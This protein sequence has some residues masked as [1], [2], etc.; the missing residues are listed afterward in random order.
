MKRD[1]NL[2]YDYCITNRV[3]MLFN[4]RADLLGICSLFGAS[5]IFD[6]IPF[7]NGI[8]TFVMMQNR[9]LINYDCSHMIGPNYYRN[10]VI[11][12]PEEFF[13]LAMDSAPSL[14]NF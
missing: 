14:V 11:L 6:R 13:R 2:I 5:H 4:S 12:H 9:D 1:N 8:I 10:Y 3:A 7:N